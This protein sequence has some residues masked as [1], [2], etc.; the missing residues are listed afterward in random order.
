M[1]VK[2][3]LTNFAALM[4]SIEEYYIII[5]VSLFW[6]PHPFPEK[7]AHVLKPTLMTNVREPAESEVTVCISVPVHHPLVNWTGC[8]VPPVRSLAAF[9]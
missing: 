8:F 9:N 1:L 6:V 5:L 2:K 7:L 3:I 4:M